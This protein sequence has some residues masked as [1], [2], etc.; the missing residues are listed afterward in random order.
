MGALVAALTGAYLAIAVGL[1]REDK[2]QVVY[3][4]NAANV[5]TLAAQIEA[6]LGRIADKV[7]LLTQG[8]QDEQWTR[9]IF[10]ADPELVSFAL[11]QPSEDGTTWNASGIVRNADY[12]KLYGA[13]PQAIDAL[14]SR[15]PVPFGEVLTRRSLAFNATLPGGAPI[16]TFALALNVVGGGGG[17]TQPRVAV[18]DLRM[19]RLLKLVS[20]AGVATIY[21]I[22]TQGRVVVHPDAK[23]VESHASLAKVPVVQEALAATVGFQLKR[24]EVGETAY[25]GAFAAVGTGGLF[26]VS[27]VEETQAFLAARRL[28]EK[29]I[30]LA[31][32]FLTASLLAAGVLAGSFT[33]P[34]EALVEATEKL[35]RG[36]FGQS[37]YVRSRD[38][39]GRLA[40]SFNAMVSDIQNQRQSLQ[41]VSRELE[42]K[43]RERTTD[44]ESQQTQVSDAQESLIRTT[45]LASLG[46]LAGA[47][48]HEV[49]NPLNNIS[50]RVER[51][52]G[53][54]QDEQANDA[55]ILSGISE[56]W[57]KAWRAGGWEKLRAE[58]ERPAEGGTQSLGEEDL[59][60]LA[61]IAKAAQK[62]VTEH[63]G[64]LEFINR[65]AARITRIVN[66]MR[67]LSRVGGERRPL[68]V[69]APIDD[70]C[71]TLAD[72]AK[73]Y[74]IALVRNFSGDPRERFV[75]LGDRDEL[76]QV[77]SNLLRNSL[78][79][80]V[81]AERRAGE[82]TIAT[83]R[84]GDRVEV[85]IS[86][87]GSGIRAV[88]LPKIFE[89]SFTT[90][91]LDE[92]TG[93]GLSISRRLAR[94]FGGDIEVERTAE[95]DG[96]TFLVW[97]PAV[98]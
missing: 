47:A 77:F 23:L 63:S 62:R 86:D 94:A 20:Q 44:L 31:V 1:F 87:N 88:D 72:A 54:L 29:S 56:G 7:A 18:I 53:Q 38:E 68:D 66:N 49:L 73:K 92:G 67:S 75:V 69:H 57:E 98:S 21:V 11:Y 32:I 26:V 71:V 48:A 30:W 42:I 34:L 12:L 59:D 39:I 91:S 13:E 96:T 89:P 93:L 46:E 55:T 2:T 19:D 36:E 17:T 81:L 41:N 60:N 4:L 85:R 65:E 22:D 28:I 80:V 58:L 50:I 16:L 6:T 3:E 25:L 51:M 24:F 90:K 84:Q 14:R 5:K 76:V 61:A 37:L 95:G 43:V 45:R 27:Q 74:G 9:A 52:R 33:R 79:A 8:H 35:A 15:F 70:T 40:R 82:V 10:A 64:D 78:Q 97:F 83:R